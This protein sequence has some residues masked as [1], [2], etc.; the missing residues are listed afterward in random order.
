MRKAL[1]ILGDLDEADV[2]WMAAVGARHSV[3]SGD[4]LIRSGQPVDTL[5]IVL[6]GEFSVYLDTGAQIARL[7][8]G[9]ILGEMS[10]VEKRPPT[11][12]VK[13]LTAAT[14][15][16]V[17]QALI[18]ERLKVEPGFAG[19]F[20]R[21]LAVF[22]SDRLRA[23]VAH[24]GYGAEASDDA[25]AQFEAEN[26]LDEGLLDTLHVAGDRMRRLTALLQGG[27]R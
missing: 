20:Y 8:A 25:L 16:A 12:S 26:E 27:G 1:Y 24:L 22:L 7:A 18:Q 17:P 2:R 21:A 6:D 23:T 4:V 11:V 3:R 15:L 10:L 5:S 19:R 13:A 9:D 14:V